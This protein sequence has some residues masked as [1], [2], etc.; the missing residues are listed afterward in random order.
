MQW[1]ARLSTCVSICASIVDFELSLSGLNPFEET[2][3]TRLSEHS[4][5]MSMMCLSSHVTKSMGTF[6]CST[7][8]PWAKNSKFLQGSLSTQAL[9]A[10]VTTKQRAMPPVARCSFRLG[11][12]LLRVASIGSCSLHK[13]KKSS[14]TECSMKFGSLI[15]TPSSK[16]AKLLLQDMGW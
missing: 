14:E 6:C 16:A 8:E 5:Q 3:S 12:S 10:T 1:H 2:T 4:S 9:G 11:W 13:S 7:K 15:K